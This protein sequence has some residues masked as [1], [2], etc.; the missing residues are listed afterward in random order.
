MINKSIVGEKKETIRKREIERQT[1]RQAETVTQNVE[2]VVTLERNRCYT[3]VEIPLLFIDEHFKIKI[4]TSQMKIMIIIIIIII[5]I[6]IIFAAQK[7]ASTYEDVCSNQN[8]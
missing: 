2:T 3:K 1:E 5:I 8:V 4:K 6:M 7:I